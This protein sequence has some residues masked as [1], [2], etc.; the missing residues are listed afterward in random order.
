[1]FPLTRVPFAV[2]IFDPQPYEGVLFFAVPL[3]THLMGRSKG[4]KREYHHVG[5]FMRGVPCFK[6]HAHN[7]H[8]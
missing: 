3:M 5:N 2:P 1:M 4:D 8:N 7:V 6:T